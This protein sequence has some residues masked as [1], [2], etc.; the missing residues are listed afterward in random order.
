MLFLAALAGAA[1]A[2]AIFILFFAKSRFGR[3]ILLSVSDNSIPLFYLGTLTLFLY[4]FDVRVL[5]QSDGII[6]SK[7]T[8]WIRF[9]YSFPYIT[10]IILYLSDPGRINRRN[11]AA[12]YEQFPFDHIL[13]LPGNECRTCLFAKPA[14]SKHCRSCNSCVAWQDHHCLWVNNC[15]GGKNFCWFLL[16]LLTNIYVFFYGTVLLMRILYTSFAPAWKDSQKWYHFGTRL[17]SRG[18]TERVAACLLLLCI[19]LLPLVALFTSF[20]IM[21]VWAGVTTNEAD[22][23]DDIRDLIPQKCLYFAPNTS[24]LL[25]KREDGTFNRHL[26][27][28]EKHL[29]L[30]IVESESDVP[31]IYDFG[32]WANLKRLLISQ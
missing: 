2:A 12:Y 9:S 29:D 25:L 11:W 16:F 5:S 30:Q 6:G 17:I 15:V 20:H 27:E 24:V 21:Y 3:R 19:L 13:Y 1:V 14:R 32:F 23:W 10:F 18:P 28:S 8:G 7:Q 26:T 31:N 22:K 4:L